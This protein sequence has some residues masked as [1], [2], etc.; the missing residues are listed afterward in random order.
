MPEIVIV[1]DDGTEHVFPDG[2]D[3]KEAAAIV[4]GGPSSPTISA[5][6]PIEAGVA[7]ARAVPAIVARTGNALTGAAK[8]APLAGQLAGKVVPGIIAGPTAKAT[9]SAV[10]AVGRIASPAPS[11]VSPILDA[12]GRAIVHQGAPSALS[13]GAGAFG[14]VMGRLNLPMLLA[15]LVTESDDRPIG[16]TAAITTERQ[17]RMAR[18]YQAM[19]NAK[20]PGAITGATV[21]EILASIAKHRSQKSW[22]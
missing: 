1:A 13:R 8:A 19:V 17:A 20:Q 3:P 14:R 11:T 4:R 18:E 5:A 7:G 22:F 6:L 12:S 16:E 21:D 10:E 2:F 15:S 9:T